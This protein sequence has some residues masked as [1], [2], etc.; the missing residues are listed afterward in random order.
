M[1]SKTQI[2]P[3]TSFGQQEGKADGAHESQMPPLP[4]ANVGLLPPI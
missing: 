2:R 1:S 3:Y 4:E